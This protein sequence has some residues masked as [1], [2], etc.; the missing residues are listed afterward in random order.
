MVEL[1]VFSKE[2]VVESIEFIVRGSKV[3][4]MGKNWGLGLG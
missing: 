2:F 4:R 1:F 3:G